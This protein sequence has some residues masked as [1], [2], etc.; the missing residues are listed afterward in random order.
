MDN[1]E[2][3]ASI[4]GFGYQFERALYRIFHSSHRDA[5][6]GI[7]TADDVEEIIPTA[8]GTISIQEQD[9]LTLA[10]KNPLQDSS[11][12]LWNTLKNW[13]DKLE[14]SQWSHQELLFMLVTN[15]SVSEGSLA[16]RLSA[17]SS[18]ASVAEAISHLRA[19]ALT[20]TGAV[21]EIAGKVTAFDDK[22]LAYVITRFEL[23]HRL[24]SDSIT[25]AM[26]TALQFPDGLDDHK[27][28]ILDS[29]SGHLFNAALESWRRKEPFWTTAQPYFNR[30]QI[31]FDKFLSEPWTARKLEDTGYRELIE[32]NRELQ[33]PFIA[34]LKELGI[35][36]RS[37]E[38]EL[39]H[40]W[41][42]YAE[43]SR[44]LLKGK[45]LPQHFDDLEEMLRD[46]WDNL[47]E[48]YSND[49]EIPL[50]DFSKADYKK[51]YLA[52]ISP[53]KFTIELGRLK[54]NH[55]YLYLGTYHHQ[56]NDDGTNHPV[57][58]HPTEGKK[59]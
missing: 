37:I 8:T 34:Q 9:K 51:I 29:L 18:T 45:I 27:K 11:R 40:Y 7:E 22:S 28:I 26:Y 20:M 42:G 16:H 10:A 19:Q 12:N 33:L 21:A 39:G 24:G 2:A 30:K 32:L 48:V 5:L 35:M 23:I 50:E 56:V 25:E 6:F 36:E 58:W 38:K 55:R 46:R 53:E 59:P 17:A 54:S 43:R 41:G 57:H 13:L 44:L 52:T 15:G 47:R 31:L 49:A 3:S 14:Q 1:T 4:A